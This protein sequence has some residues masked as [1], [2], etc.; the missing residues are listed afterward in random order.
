MGR[1]RR[2]LQPTADALLAA[3]ESVVE[4]EGLPA[5]TVRRVASEVET[6]TRAVYATYGSKDALLVALGQKAYE[7]LDEKVRA[8]PATSD[9]IHDLIEAGLIF[10]RFAIEHPTLFA[11]GIQRDQV[12]ADLAPEIQTMAAR[13]FETLQHRFRPL[14]SAGRLAAP[15]P[16]S[17]ARAFHALCE[18]IASLESRAML[19][20]GNEENSWREALGFLLN[21]LT[22]ERN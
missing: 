14:E 5:L 18:G 16:L 8:L 11:I 13:A 21:G 7:I 3:A 4:T 10:R 12:P 20:Q 17:A 19:P 9:P 1:P 22:T 15:S 2:H 6:S